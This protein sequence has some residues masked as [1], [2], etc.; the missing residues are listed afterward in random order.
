MEKSSDSFHKDPGRFR[1]GPLRLISLL[2]LFSMVV[3]CGETADQQFVH[4]KES[5]LD[6]WF[7][8]HSEKATWAG[9]HQYDQ[10]LPDVAQQ[11]LQDQKQLYQ[12]TLKDLNDLKNTELTYQHQLDYEVLRHA[13]HYMIFQQDTLRVY[14]DNPNIYLKRLIASITDLA[15]QQQDSSAEQIAHLQARL[16]GIPSWLN[17]AY[18]NLEP[19]PVVYLE[20]AATHAR[21]LARFFRTG[22]FFAYLD[23]LNA[24]ARQEM[25]RA[26]QS[27]ADGLDNFAARLENELI[28]R[29]DQS[30]RLGENLFR[31]NLHYLVPPEWT[32]AAV[33][34]RAQASLSELQDQIY[35]IADTLAYRWW[36]IRYARPSRATRLQIIRRVLERIRE[37]FPDADERQSYL[38]S[39]LNPLRDFVSQH[40]VLTESLNWPIQVQINPLGS[41][42]AL[43]ASLH[44]TGPLVAVFRTN[45]SLK[46][47]P[48]TWTIQQVRDYLREFNRQAEQLD[49]IHQEFP[50]T[51]ALRY[52]SK[53][54]P[55]LI[56]SL[57]PNQAFLHGWGYYTERMLVDE[58]W[59]QDDPRVRLNQLIR[60]VQ[61]AGAALV[62]QRVH[63]QNMS[64]A[65]AISLLTQQS[66]YTMPAA[67]VEWQ[68]VQLAPGCA[69]TAFV[70]KEEIWDL[71]IKYSRK[72]GSNFSLLDFHNRLLSYGIIPISSLR[73]ILLEG[74]L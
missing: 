4:I 14:A 72:M 63:T 8:W 59:G 46:P 62:D 66:F 29:S 25:G 23:S 27:A 47:L 32:T 40:K 19:G 18:Q 13:L 20:V 55:S 70:G 42:E 49:L 68:A 7:Q 16:R 15:M 21:Q 57:F 69:T 38:V 58:G 74:K 71:R 9:I 34:S 54:Y 3:G 51:A 26:L 17:Q 10:L 53:R 31:R 1:P 73:E 52:Y 37:D 61:V 67:E 50:G 39:Q 36:N 60:E 48:A 43:F 45:L 28:P 11:A 6:Q 65:A 44:T 35:A 33:Q 56:R 24:P 22:N 41:P 64:R 5:F 2:L 12:T 30:F